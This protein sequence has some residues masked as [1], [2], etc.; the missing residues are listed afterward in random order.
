MQ[1]W[2]DKLNIQNH[3]FQSANFFNRRKTCEVVAPISETIVTQKNF[4]NVDFIDNENIQDLNGY[5]NAFIFN[6][7][8]IIVT[9]PTLNIKYAVGN[10]IALQNN[11]IQYFNVDLT[12]LTWI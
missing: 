1:N 4:W 8:S 11:Q 10:N 3:Y 5:L 12:N 6:K 2:N 9:H 7:T